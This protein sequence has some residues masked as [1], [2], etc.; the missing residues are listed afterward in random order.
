M[1][2]EYCEAGSKPYWHSGVKRL[3]HEGG[4]LCQTPEKNCT[5]HEGSVCSEA[6]RQG[7]HHEGCQRADTSDARDYDISSGRD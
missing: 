2:C 1:S 7:K 4:V 5:C 3:A 6:C